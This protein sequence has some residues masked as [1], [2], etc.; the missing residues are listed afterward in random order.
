MRKT[1]LKSARRRGLWKCGQ[2]IRLAHSPIGEQKQKKRTFDGLPK[3][4][5]LHSLATGQRSDDPARDRFRRGPAPARHAGTLC[6]LAGREAHQ[7]A[8]LRGRCARARGPESRAGAR[9]S[10]CSDGS[11]PW[12]ENSRRRA[13]QL[14]SPGRARPPFFSCARAGAA[15]AVP[16]RFACRRGPGGIARCDSFRR[17]SD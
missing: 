11:L 13:V 1:P 3:T 12:V 8:A 6:P 2:G 5:Q 4:G 16:C 9:D 17:L 15:Q 10:C 14:Q 7:G